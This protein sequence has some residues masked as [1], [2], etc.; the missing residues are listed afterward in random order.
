MVNPA[1]RLGYHDFPN[2]VI[3]LARLFTKL[4]LSENL[5]QL[6]TEVFDLQM[7][8]GEDLPDTNDLD[9]FWARFHQIRSP[10]STKPTYSTLLVLVCAL[11]AFPASNADNERCFSMVRKIDSEDHSHLEHNTVASL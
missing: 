4:Q 10:G 3:Q 8:S 6:K 2:A 1:E 11:L 7:A 5:D 9:N